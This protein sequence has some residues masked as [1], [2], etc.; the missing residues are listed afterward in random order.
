ME[1][2]TTPLVSVIMSCY[3]NQ[4]T[5]LEAIYSILNQ[6]V[7]SFEFI[8][9]DDCSTDKTLEIIKSIK[10]DRIVLIRNNSNRGLGYNLNYG[11]RVSKGKYIARMDADDI[12]HPQ[13]FDYQIKYLE[14]HKDVVCLGTSAKKIGRL[15]LRTRLF[16]LYM[17]QCTS[18]EE[19]KVQL[20]L[21]TPM[22]HPSVMFRAD[23]LIE[24]DINYNINFKKA[25]DYE[26]FSRLAYLAKITNLSNYLFYYR[27]SEKQASVINR[28]EQI[29]NS[30]II[31]NRLLSKILKRD[32]TTN[33]LNNHVLFATKSKMSLDDLNSVS[34]WLT[35]FYQELSHL[36]TEIDLNILQT[37]FSLRWAVI[38]R[39]SI[40]IASRFSLFKSNKY[41]GILSLKNIS[42]LI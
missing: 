2:I 21:G 4:D 32:I 35:K 9:I 25:Q 42:H 39:N 15:S 33:E 3:N 29:N 30:K 38:C 28:E 37:V 41:F 11:I 20:L 10:D 27:Y 1:K 16:S 13:R 18:W 17:N 14:A 8:I 7:T 6:T 34:S 12:S 19:I 40:P 31:Y 24:L 22:L 36:D 5:V 23:S 26:L